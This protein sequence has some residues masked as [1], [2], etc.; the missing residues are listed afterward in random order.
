MVEGL[1]TGK[2]YL[3]PIWSPFFGPEE[4]H[5]LKK[6]DASTE[7]ILLEFKEDSSLEKDNK[8][9]IL[10]PRKSGNLL[11]RELRALTYHLLSLYDEDVSIKEGRRRIFMKILKEGGR[12][13]GQAV[14]GGFAKFR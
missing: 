9:V 13:T 8:V 14:F 1:A 10:N 7:H 12:R 4:V 5:V 6:I 11:R 3:I 2:P